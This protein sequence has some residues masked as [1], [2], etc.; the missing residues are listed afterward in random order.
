L[1]RTPNIIGKKIRVVIDT[2][3]WFVILPPT[4]AYNSILESLLSG[5]FDLLVSNEI[6]IECEEILKIKFKKPTVTNFLALLD[7]LPNL[8]KTNVSFNFELIKNDSDG[9]KFMDY[10]IAG[11][12]DFIVTEDGHFRVMKRVPF[13]LH[14]KAHRLKTVG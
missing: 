11:Q 13:T 9:N 2:N 6:L 7:N 3:C 12:T 8:L 14:K 5:D 10:A 4:S 1:Y